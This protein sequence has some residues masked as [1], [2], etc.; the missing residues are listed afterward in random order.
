MIIWS[1]L[2]AMTKDCSLSIVYKKTNYAGATPCIEKANQLTKPWIPNQTTTRRKVPCQ[3]AVVASLQD[4]GC[5]PWVEVFRRSSLSNPS[6][7]S[8][9]RSIAIPEFGCL[10]V[11]GVHA[12]VA[13]CLRRL[14]PDHV[15]TSLVEALDPHFERRKALNRPTLTLVQMPAGKD[16]L[17]KR[18]MDDYKESVS[19][20]PFI[21]TFRGT[22]R[23]LIEYRP[24]CSKVLSV[25]QVQRIELP[26]FN[27]QQP[28]ETRPNRPCRIHGRKATSR[29]RL[30]L[31]FQTPTQLMAPTNGPRYSKSQTELGSNS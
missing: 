26:I 22:R 25:P 27:H 12:L 9:S 11:Y 7:S 2:L 6:N 8:I 19:Y 3:E 24:L 31:L 30:Q 5:F 1:T 10:N 21:G 15:S 28:T 4:Y 13:H 16:S 14:G 20:L 17:R 18:E 29:G 23:G